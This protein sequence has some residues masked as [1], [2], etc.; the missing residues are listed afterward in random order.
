MAAD[1]L[2][3]REI[4][5]SMTPRINLGSQSIKNSGNLVLQ[6]N[7][8]SQT[9]SLNEIKDL[10]ADNNRILRNVANTMLQSLVLDKDN[11]RRQREQQAELNKEMAKMSKGGFIGPMMPG[12]GSGGSAGGDGEGG[13]LGTAALA[14]GGALGL[15]GLLKSLRGFKLGKGIEGFFGVN[16]GFS[17][18]GAAK[19]GAGGTAKT[20]GM[21]GL[22]GALRMGTGKAGL[23]SAIL[24]VPSVIMS[25]KDVQDAK[26]RDDM[27]GVAEAKDDIAGTVGGTGGALAGA[28]AG[29]AVGSVVP[30]IGT[31]IG[32]IVGGILGGMGGDKLGRF[33][34]TSAEEKAVKYGKRIELGQDVLKGRYKSWGKAYFEQAKNG[35][36]K[37]YR[38]RDS[39]FGSV[40]ADPD[41]IAYLNGK[42]SELPDYGKQKEEGEKDAKIAEE[43]DKKTAAS[44]SGT[45]YD[46]TDSATANVVNQDEKGET[47][48]GGF[49]SK[50]KSF[51]KGDKISDEEL[52]SYEDGKKEGIFNIM[53]TD[54][55]VKELD[56][57]DLGNI[58]KELKDRA[59]ELG[60][61]DATSKM[62]A[63]NAKRLSMIIP[64]VLNSLPPFETERRAYLQGQLNEALDILEDPTYQEALTEGETF[65]DR[66]VKLIG[67]SNEDTQA[68]TIGGDTRVANTQ[69]GD[70]ST[71]TFGQTITE[72][73]SKN[74]SNSFLRNLLRDKGEPIETVNI[75]SSTDKMKGDQGESVY[76]SVMAEKLKGSFFGGDDYRIRQAQLPDGRVIQNV[77][78]SKEQYEML[79]K[80]QDYD[81]EFEA[82]DKIQA[83]AN[84]ALGEQPGASGTQIAQGN[85]TTPPVT[86]QGENLQPVETAN[87]VNIS[88]TPVNNTTNNTIANNTTNS[89]RVDTEVDPYVDRIATM[90]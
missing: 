52:L 77:P 47:K 50:A 24:A 13:G 20:L 39:W 6:Q 28:A 62:L 69:K 90:T 46:L 22:K 55:T 36:W 73:T 89:G 40:V 18:K 63:L 78:I 70:E 5:Q 64:N 15:S 2:Q 86:S 65:K 88:N 45:T 9:N 58:P 68:R 21:R 12:G 82:Q 76:A 4:A 61:N 16:K 38:K 1:I 87:G 31:A 66:L 34:F 7:E 72:E 57:Y 35:N 53:S 71:S 49:F 54:G 74:I 19:L 10:T 83:I 56:Q 29:A 44:L 41:L 27:E 30:V 32:G 67:G 8:I 11:I 26:A 23:L 79:K 48:T 84:T 25:L 37:V 75:T 85:V 60:G 51:F 42:I 80:I 81:N 3:F 59:K 43:D 17:L 33:F 14:A